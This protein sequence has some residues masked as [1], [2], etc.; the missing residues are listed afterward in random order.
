MRRYIVHHCLLLCVYLMLYDTTDTCSESDE[1]ENPT[2]VVNYANY[3][4][5]IWYK[6]SHSGNGPFL[7]IAQNE[8]EEEIECKLA[9]RP[10]EESSYSCN[11]TDL[12]FDETDSYDITV[13]DSTTSKKLSEITQFIPKCNIK[14]DPPSGLSYNVSEGNYKITWAGNEKFEGETKLQYELQFKTITSS[15]QRATKKDISNSDMFAMIMSSEFEKGSI[16]N[17]RIRCKTEETGKLFY[18]SQWSDWSSEIKIHILGK[19]RSH[20]NIYPIIIIIAI[21]MMMILIL[22]YLVY[23]SSLSPRIQMIFLQKVPTAADFFQ[24]LYHEHNGNFQDWTKYPNKNVQSKKNRLSCNIPDTDL[25]SST[26]LCFQKEIISPIKVEAPTP[27]KD[28]LSLHEAFG[29]ESSYDPHLQQKISLEEVYPSFSFSP[30]SPIL[31][32]KDD[33]NNSVF[34]MDCPADYFSTDGTYI[35]N[36]Q[37]LVN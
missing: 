15:W 33:K 16:Y 26:V 10:Y 8:G 18:K 17:V 5:C 4:S 6:G 32:Y 13:Q 23:F 28:V 30:D 37:E 19:Y 34:E 1:S 3:M 36:S 21:L 20:F 14:L 29:S 22:L 27:R 11:I 31:N 2:C 12:F 35:A 9:L 7:V 25:Y 24:P